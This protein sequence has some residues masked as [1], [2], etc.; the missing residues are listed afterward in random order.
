[1][2]FSDYKCTE[3]DHVFEY[4]K[5]SHI[6]S[7]PEFV[8]CE[9]CGSD[10]KRIIGRIVVDMAEGKLGNSK[11]NFNNNVVYHSGAIV[12]KVKGVRIK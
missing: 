8:E 9:K 7:F 3:C 5:I 1:M 10:S 2:V 6:E 11:S 12:G 4:C